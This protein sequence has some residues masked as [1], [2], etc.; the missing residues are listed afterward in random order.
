GLFTPYGAAFARDQFDA[1]WLGANLRGGLALPVL[2]ASG[3]YQIVIDPVGTGTGSVTATLS[4][5][6]TG[7][8]SLTG[9]GTTV[10][11]GRAGQQ[12]ELTFAVTA[13]QRIGIG[14]TGPTFGAATTATTKLLEPNGAPMLWSNAQDRGLVGIGSGDNLDFSVTQNGSYTI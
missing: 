9:A 1:P 6:V 8:L 12:A 2:P 3:T 10:T 11:L 14:F 7:A 13:G 4:T 5:R